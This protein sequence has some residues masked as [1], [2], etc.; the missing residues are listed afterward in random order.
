VIEVR[1]RQTRV[2][3]EQTTALAAERL[4]APAGRLSADELS[5]VDA[6]LTVVFGL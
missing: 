5:A 6:A 2:L 4:G 1:G 3:V